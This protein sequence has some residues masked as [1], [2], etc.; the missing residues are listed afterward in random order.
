[1]SVFFYSR[2]SIHNEIQREPS[3]LHSPPPSA[4]IVLAASPGQPIIPPTAVPSEESPVHS[5]LK[6]QPTSP[7][8]SVTRFTSQTLSSARSRSVTLA[9]S[10]PQ[11]REPSTQPP[12][13][14]PLGPSAQE[15]YLPENYESSQVYFS[16]RPGGPRIYDLLNTLPLAPFGVLSWFII[17]REEE[18]FELDDVL[19]EDKVMQALWGRWIMLNQ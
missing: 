15:P 19:D 14:D 4:A 6:Q 16:C 18:L 12:L 9:S 1:M 3:Q 13:E 10:R 7:P 8:R 5:K 2:V 17:D 11:T